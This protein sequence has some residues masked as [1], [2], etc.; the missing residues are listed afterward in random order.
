MQF[1]IVQ[2]FTYFA[3]LYAWMTD[4]PIW[5]GNSDRLLADLGAPAAP[6]SV[7]DLGAGPGNSALAMGRSRP[8]A[9][10]IAFDLSFAMLELAQRTRRQAQWPAHRL[11]PLQGDAQRIPLAANQLHAVTGH[12]F[13]YLLPRPDLV[14]AEAYRVL[15][16]GGV[17]AFLE[18]RAGAA[19]W[20]WLWRQRSVPFILSIV[21]WRLYSRLHRRFC[22]DELEAALSQAGFRQV[23]TEATL[24]NF[25]LF[26]RGY[27]P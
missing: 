24:G 13:L 18:P 6:I 12:S 17:V 1:P 16:P 5:L 15:R 4:N 10:F 22:A 8:G 19:D 2:A 25:A 20:S 11:I 14:L 7:L 27:K 9:S 23:R 21:L 26:A 3:R